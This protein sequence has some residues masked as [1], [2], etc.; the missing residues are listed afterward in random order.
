M[1]IMGLFFTQIKI[2]KKGTQNW[3]SIADHEV[4][5]MIRKKLEE[6][7]PEDGFL[8]E[9]SGT[10]NLDADKCLK[11]LLNNKIYCCIVV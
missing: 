1:M 2:E 5:K 7:F 11:S 6:L 9:E 8:G 4:E 10:R 3:V